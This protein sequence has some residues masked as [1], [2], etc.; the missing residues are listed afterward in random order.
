VLREERH[1]IGV[2]L[3]E[4]CGGTEYQLWLRLASILQEV[5]HLM[6][7]TDDN[8]GCVLDNVL[9]VGDGDQVSGKFDVGKISRVFMC[10][11]NHVGQLLAL[12]LGVN[13]IHLRSSAR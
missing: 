11:V 5:A 8:E 13:A 1:R 6:G 3:I 10:S 12:D 4:Q 9:Q 7:H 2:S